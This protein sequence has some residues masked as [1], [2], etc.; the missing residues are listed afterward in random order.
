VS[1]EF[2][3]VDLGNGRST[4]RRVGEGAPVAR[5]SLPTP[6]II[7]DRM[8]ATEHPCDGRFYE[9]KS[10]FR[11]VTRQHGCIEVGTEK[12]KPKPNT[13]PD[14]KGIRESIQKAIAK[15]GPAPKRRRR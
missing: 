15:A 1:Y 13:E 8:E 9:S 10:A 4:Y 6:M 3:W 14:S 7:S 11:K 12:L 5:S 2:Q